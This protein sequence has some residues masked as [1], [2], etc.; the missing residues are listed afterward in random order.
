MKCTSLPTPHC[1]AG[2]WHVF[3][4]EGPN[5]KPPI[6]KLMG[7]YGI[8]GW[9]HRSKSTEGQNNRKNAWGKRWVG[10]KVAQLV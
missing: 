1:C 8:Q 4:I 6:A 2:Y 3:F 7:K 5:G 10:K 9:Y